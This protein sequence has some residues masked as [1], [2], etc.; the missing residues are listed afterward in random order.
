MSSKDRGAPAFAK[1]ALIKTIR[2]HLT[3][4]LAD[5]RA[6]YLEEHGFDIPLVMPHVVGNRPLRNQKWPLMVIGPEENR[7]DA[8]LTRTTVGQVEGNR[9]P[10]RAV[11]QNT[12][13]AELGCINNKVIK[14]DNELEMNSAEV[15]SVQVENTLWALYYLFVDYNFNEHLLAEYQGPPSPNT[16]EVSMTP[17][18]MR[19][20]PGPRNE[21]KEILTEF[22]VLVFSLSIR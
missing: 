10:G 7:I 15:T 21:E 19:L 8:D 1:Q 13:Q 12:L 14:I 2:K 9:E 20:V 5:V 3:L 22:G 11:F 16:P 6:S 4:H 18:V 17:Q